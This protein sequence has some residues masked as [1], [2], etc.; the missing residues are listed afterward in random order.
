MSTVEEGGGPVVARR[1]VVR[2]RVQGV[3]FRAST[4]QVAR[5]LGVVG[6]V[7]NDPGGTVT[8]HAEGS[9]AAV[10]ELLRWAASGPRHAVVVGVDVR[11]A[12]NAGH[13]QFE[14]RYR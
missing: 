10:D 3:F 1:A 8:L 13:E 9:A 14:V 11:Q 6:W 4:Q 5:R 12:P 2:G 7:R